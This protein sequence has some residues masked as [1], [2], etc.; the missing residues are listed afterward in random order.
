MGFSSYLLTMSPS[1]SILFFTLEN[2]TLEYLVNISTQP[3]LSSNAFYPSFEVVRP[4]ARIPPILVPPT[5][6]NNLCIGFLVWFS[7]N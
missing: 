1:G 7:I 4:S 5:Q 3:L 6:L 2:I